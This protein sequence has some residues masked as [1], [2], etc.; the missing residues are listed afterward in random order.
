MLLKLGKSGETVLKEV[1]TRDNIMPSQLAAVL[2]VHQS[3]ISRW[4]ARSRGIKEVA[5]KR[6]LKL[7]GL[8][9]DDLF[10]IDTSKETS[11]DN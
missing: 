7:T 5:R 6:L 9:F 4:Y 10:E 11:F 3:L 8:T 1:L 2:A